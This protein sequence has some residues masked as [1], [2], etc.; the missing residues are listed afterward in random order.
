MLPHHLERV[1]RSK[2]THAQQIVNAFPENTAPKYLIRD[3][4]GIYGKEFVG[5]VHGLGVQEKLI[6]PRSP[7]QNP[8][9]ERL[10]GSIRRECLDHMVVFGQGHLHRILSRFVDY[11]QNH[12]PHRSLDQDSPLP[13]RIEPPAG[14]GILELPVLGGLHHRYT[15]QAA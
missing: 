3:R 13:R 9:V 5:R 11:Y 10:I 2:P 7:W 12:R 4:D 15:R 1:S 6:A 14:G 8:F